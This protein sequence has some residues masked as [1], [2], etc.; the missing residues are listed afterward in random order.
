MPKLATDWV[1]YSWLSGSISYS[2]YPLREEDIEK[3]VIAFTNAI[4]ENFSK[5]TFGKDPNLS[6]QLGLSA[7]DRN[8][9]RQKNDARS[10][11]SRFLDQR[12]K[13]K[14]NILQAEVNIMLRQRKD[15]VWNRS[16]RV[17]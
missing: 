5:S 13:I 17:G 8:L 6:K 14:V 1:P 4:Q 15:E 2:A 7:S 16:N 9:I 3:E 10:R 12:D 11:Y